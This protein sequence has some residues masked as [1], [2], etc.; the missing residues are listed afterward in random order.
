MA[1]WFVILMTIGGLTVNKQLDKAVKAFMKGDERAFNYIYEH[2][3]VP[4]YYTILGILKD[5]SLAEDVMQDTY[6]KMIE[7]LPKYTP[8]HQFTA[9]I[10]TIARNQALNLY[11]RRAK[12][13]M[14]DVNESDYLLE[15]VFSRSEDQYFLK[16]LLATLP[17]DEREIVIA[18]AVME[19]KHKDIAK[20]LDM[21]LGTVLWKYRKALKALKK[22]GG[23]SHEEATT[24][25]RQK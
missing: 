5:K 14:V 13:Q 15:K 6:L 21:P 18:H 10:K 19:E 2:T 16:E 11:N 20:R 3:R 1:L 25:H 7:Q 8:K 23:V 24:G 4:V 22:K 9:W 17:A 12:E